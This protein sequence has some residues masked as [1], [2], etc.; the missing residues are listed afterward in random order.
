MSVV[1]RSKT[2]RHGVFGRI[3][4]LPP[5]DP[6]SRRNRHKGTEA[7]PTCIDC[8][9]DRRTYSVSGMAE[10]TARVLRANQALWN[11]ASRVSFQT[12][13]LG[14]K[15]LSHLSKQKSTEFWARTV[16]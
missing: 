3:P 1:R 5:G 7:R 15:A 4:G 6:T 12:R 14:E 8:F 11:E 10:G 9:A 13:I 16:S 2:L